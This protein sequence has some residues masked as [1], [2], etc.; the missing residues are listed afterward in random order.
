MF[1]L[2][3]PQRPLPRPLLL[4]ER[5]SRLHILQLLRRN[6]FPF[7]AFFNASIFW[8]FKKADRASSL[9]LIQ[10]DHTLTNGDR[11]FRAWTSGS[12]L[13]RVLIDAGARQH[14]AL[15]QKKNT[16]QTCSP[17]YPVVR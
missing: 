11:V 14:L 4:L 5:C 15:Q 6:L 16:H 17:S 8:A 12:A 7:S 3:D 9:P 10:R 13:G 2:S 1:F